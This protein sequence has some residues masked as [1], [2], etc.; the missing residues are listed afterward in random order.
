MIQEVAFMT[1]NKYHIVRAQT[2]ESE[3]TEP[4]LSQFHILFR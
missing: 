1:A 4:M 3:T 2:K